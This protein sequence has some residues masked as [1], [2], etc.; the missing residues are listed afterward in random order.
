MAFG[1]EVV[2]EL[3]G[4]AFAILFGHKRCAW[5][6][7]FEHRQ[8]VHRD[9]GAAPGVGRGRQVIGVGFTGHFEHGDGDFLLDFGALLEPLGVGPGLDDLF[10]LGVAR[11]GF[12]GNV[13]E[14]VEHQQRAFERFAGFRSHGRIVEQINEWLDVVATEHG[15]QQLCGTLACDQAAR[16]LAMGHRCQKAGLDFGGVIHA[17]WDAMHQ[18][19]DQVA[20]FACGRVFD[21]LNDVSG[22]L[23]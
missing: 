17:G 16:L 19:V 6:G 2:D 4:A 20:F 9:V 15:A 14:C 12:F 18:Q 8:V 13:V 11:L 22:L 5:A 21:Q 7:V 23:G 1:F 3:H 10:G